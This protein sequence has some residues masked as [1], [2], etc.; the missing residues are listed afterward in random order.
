[1]TDYSMDELRS[2]LERVRYSKNF[3]T[4]VRNTIYSLITVAAA[5]VLIALLVMPV[6]RIYGDS[7]SP[8]LWEGNIVLSLKGSKFKTGDVIAFYYNNK[9]LIKR[10]IAQPGQWVDIDKDGT[11]YVDNVMIHEPYITDKAFGECDLK[12]PYQVPES[13]IFVMGDH[14]NV[15]VDSRNTSIGCV[16]EEQVVGKVVFRVWPLNSLGTVK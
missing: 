10:V 8:T 3:S 7:M 14:R 5:A 12:L 13:R 2:E 1:M 11:V 15:S 6:L 4:A 9:I 16:A